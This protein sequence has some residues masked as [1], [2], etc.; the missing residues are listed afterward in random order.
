MRELTVIGP[1][2]AWPQEAIQSTWK[3]GNLSA[4]R[5]THDLSP[6]LTPRKLNR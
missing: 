6:R 3:T 4:P 2:T 5:L 1:A